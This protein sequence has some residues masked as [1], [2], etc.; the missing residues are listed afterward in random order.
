MHAARLEDRPLLLALENGHFNFQACIFFAQL[1]IL[2]ERRFG[3]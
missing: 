3:K 1:D 2:F